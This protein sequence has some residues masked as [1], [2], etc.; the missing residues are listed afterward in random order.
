MRSQLATLRGLRRL[1]PVVRRHNSEISSDYFD[2]LNDALEAEGSHYFQK[3]F[4]STYKVS[5][6][7]RTPFYSFYVGCSLWHWLLLFSL[8]TG[9]RLKFKEGEEAM[10]VS[11]SKVRTEQNWWRS[12]SIVQMH[13]WAACSRCQ[14]PI[15]S[16]LYKYWIY[17]V[18]LSYHSL[19]WSDQLASKVDRTLDTTIC[20]LLVLSTL[21]TSFIAT[22]VE[23]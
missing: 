16:L 10:G 12:S 2:D 4:N 13:K 15:V 22:E 20:L 19:L 1:F 9:L 21:F 3:E 17:K 18:I 6:I 8:S 23:V 7:C 11:A 14:R 5:K